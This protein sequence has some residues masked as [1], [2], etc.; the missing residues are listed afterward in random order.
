[1]Y[2]L[3]NSPEFPNISKKN[4]RLTSPCTFTYNCIAWAA[5]DNMRFWWPSL[6]GV[7]YWPPTIPRETTVTAFT[8]AFN[9]LGYELC[10][11]DLTRV[12]G[13]EKV[14]LYTDNEGLPTHMCRQLP[15]GK[16]TSKMGP[17]QD[18]EHDSPDVLNGPMYGS[19]THCY[20]RPELKINI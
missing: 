1:M 4:H 17:S 8:M 9:E 20:K 10:D 2:P 6:D 19:A 3:V 13:V 7:T 18:I 14:V 11:Y 16:W 12:I 15:S 5:E